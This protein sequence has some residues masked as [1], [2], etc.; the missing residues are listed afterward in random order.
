MQRALRC[1]SFYCV[2]WF[3]IEKNAIRG[4]RTWVGVRVNEAAGAGECFPLAG[5]ALFELQAAEAGHLAGHTLHGRARGGAL[6]AA[7]KRAGRHTSS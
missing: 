6:S 3:N 4:I 1:S 7:G 2:C 5:H